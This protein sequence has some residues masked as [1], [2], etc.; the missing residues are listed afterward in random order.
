MKRTFAA[1]AGVVA[2]AGLSSLAHAQGCS[3]VGCNDAFSVNLSVDVPD[4]FGAA[5]A[6]G[7]FAASSDA[8]TT[9][10]SGTSSAAAVGALGG[11]GTASNSTEAHA[12]AANGATSGGS[13]NSSASAG[14]ATP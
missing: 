2:L 8:T 11:T 6:T 1:L 3:W 12:T 5:T 14:P 13:S 9:A 7:N 4:N 10:T